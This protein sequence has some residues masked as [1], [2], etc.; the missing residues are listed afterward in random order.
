MFTEAQQYA[1][2]RTELDD[3]FKQ[4]FNYEDSNPVMTTCKNS[5]IF[6][7]ETTDRAFDIEE[8][9]KGVN[10]FPSISEVQTVPTSTPHVANKITTQIKDFAES[11]SLSKDLFDDNIKHLLSSNVF[12]KRFM[13][14]IVFA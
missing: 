5:L 9:Y 4:E 2:V 1:I 3:V 14:N 6:R 11:V 8:I 12:G 10:L 7:Q 13:Q